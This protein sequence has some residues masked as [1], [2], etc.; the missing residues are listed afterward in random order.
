MI[1]KFKLDKRHEQLKGW[2]AWGGGQYRHMVNWLLPQALTLVHGAVNQGLY[3]CYCDFCVWWWWWWWTS[4][5]PVWHY[6]YQK[7]PHFL[8]KNCLQNLH[9]QSHLQGSCLQHHL[10]DKH[11]SFSPDDWQGGGVV[12][13]WQNGWWLQS[14]LAINDGG[15]M[16]AAKRCLWSYMMQFHKNLCFCQVILLLQYSNI[17]SC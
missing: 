8:C 15:Q 12:A 14:F 11:S 17:W 3:L 9:W 7:I 1:L 4:P 13:D 10:V 2:Q 16:K 6:W 5:H